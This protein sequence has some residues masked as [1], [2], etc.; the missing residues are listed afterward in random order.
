MA[1]K[2]MFELTIFSY[3]T[4]FKLSRFI[5]ENQLSRLDELGKKKLLFDI[6]TEL[7][8]SARNKH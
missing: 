1:D 6:Y 3:Q 4:G 2:Y 7:E 8:H 5:P